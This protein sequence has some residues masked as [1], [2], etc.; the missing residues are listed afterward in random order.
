MMRSIFITIA[1]F[2]ALF[3]LPGCSSFKD[4]LRSLLSGPDIPVVEDMDYS[5]PVMSAVV[6]RGTILF[7]YK[8]GFWEKL[9]YNPD[10]PVPA[11]ESEIIVYLGFVLDFGWQSGWIPLERSGSR[12]V[13]LWGDTD[14]RVGKCDIL[15]GNASSE[16]KLVIRKNPSKPAD[17]ESVLMVL[18]S[19]TTKTVSVEMND[20]ISTYRV[21]HSMPPY[22]WGELVLSGRAYRIFSVIEEAYYARYPDFSQRERGIDWNGFVIGTYGSRV[23][24]TAKNFLRNEQK[25]QIL[26][27]SD[28]VV[29][30]LHENNY[31][32]YDSLPQTE[33]DNMKQ[34]LA[35][36]HAFRYIAQRL[37][38][39]D[40]TGNNVYKIYKTL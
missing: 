4:A 17:N 34:A 37:M 11:N 22:S 6:E 24:T 36:F 18:D 21:M 12:G 38:E 20:Y 40:S 14:K 10:P 23:E 15:F 19:A 26:G 33:W 28:T 1:F 32:L 39:G 16:G 31:T 30:E 25:F 7:K 35:L 27:N 8:P 5:Y 13:L 3:T 9:F 2:T 29:A